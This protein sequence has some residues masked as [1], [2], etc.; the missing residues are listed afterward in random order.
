MPET[1][2]MIERLLGGRK[3]S[4]PQTNSFE[5]V[6][7]NT[8]SFAPWAGNVY[9]NDIARSAIWTIAEAA[10]KASFVHARGEGEDMKLFPDPAIRTVLEQPNEFLTMQHLINK[11]V[12]HLEKYNNAFAL[13]VRDARGHPLSIYPLDY[14][15]VELRESADH[16]VYCKFRFRGTKDIIAPYHDIIHLR[17]HFDADEFFGE[18]NK[19]ALSD[20]MEII[21][22]TDQGIVEAVKNSAVIKWILKFNS[23]LRPDDMKARAKEFSETYLKTT[24]NGAGVAAIDQH[25]EVTQVKTDA[26]VPNAPQLDKAKQRIYAYYG[27]NDAIVQRT[28]DENAWN[29]WYESTIEPILIQFA[30]QMTAKFFTTKERAFHNRIVPESAS[31]QY[32]SMQTKLALVSMV[33]RGAMKPNEWRRIL[34]LA[35]VEGGDKPIR[36][37]DTKIIEEFDA[38]ERKPIQDDDKLSGS[39]VIQAKVGNAEDESVNGEE[40][41]ARMQFG[42]RHDWA[43]EVRAS[44][45][46]GEQSGMWVEGRAIVYDTETMMFEN[47]G[48]KYYERIVSGALDNAD[49]SEVVMRYNHSPNNLVIARH[50]SSRP[51]RSNLQLIPDSQGLMIRADLSKTESGRQL[52]EAIQAGLVDRMSFAFTIEEE[53]YNKDTRTLSILKIKKLWDV[54]AVDTPAYDTTS[55]Y[56]RDRLQAEAEA[57]RRAA[58]AARRRKDT[59]SLEIQTALTIYGGTKR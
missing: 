48:N 47:E 53:S 38:N 34:N 18:S 56:A 7:V 33:D 45:M 17:K 57:E 49:I 27:V 44:E 51:N 30:Q 41:R 24:E 1:R 28:Y 43:F 37:L 16:E 13:I 20:V 12:V 21:G 5:L 3:K 2:S 31:L 54:S 26:F 52:Y 32:A 19:R 9:E 15:T 6:N 29:A 58:D 36:R 14:S 55:I 25:N 23:V 42:D 39:T 11:M 46:G 8:A 50:V 4:T 22:I 59:L 40:Q 10:G 35:P